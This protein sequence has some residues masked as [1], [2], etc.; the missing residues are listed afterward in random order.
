MFGPFDTQS[1]DSVEDT[2]YRGIIDPAAAAQIE[3]ERVLRQEDINEKRGRRVRRQLGI[4]QR[5]LTRPEA[6]LDLRTGLNLKR[7]QLKIWILIRK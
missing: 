2:G 6:L 1:V 5:P 7:R 4:Y 3:Q